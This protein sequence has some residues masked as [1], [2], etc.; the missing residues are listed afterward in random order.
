MRKGDEIPLI[1]T[2]RLNVNMDYHPLSW[3]TLSLTGSYVGKQWLRGDEANQ[4]RPLRGCLET[5]P[6]Y[7][8]RLCHIQGKAKNGL[9]GQSVS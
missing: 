1:P 8:K 3:L 7:E 4:E 9:T 6:L 2:H 5:K